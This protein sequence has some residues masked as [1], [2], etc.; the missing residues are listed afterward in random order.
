MH[1]AAANGEMDSSEEGREGSDDY[2]WG[3]QGISVYQ[4]DDGS[5]K[6]EAWTENA[7]KLATGMA[8]AVSVAMSLI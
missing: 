6:I 2:D 4:N 3:K 8:A 1:A 5:L 7:V